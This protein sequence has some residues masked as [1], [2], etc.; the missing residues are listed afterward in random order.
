[1]LKKIKKQTI[2]DYLFF[3]IIC[4]VIFKL[5]FGLFFPIFVI[6]SESM[7]PYLDVGD[8]VFIKNKSIDEYNNGCIIVY[9]PYGN[10]KI[11]PVIHRI[12]YYIYK[13]ELMWPFGPI[14]QHSGFITKGDNNLL[15]K[16]LDQQS[17]ICTV[18]IKY[19]WVIG[20]KKIVIK[21]VGKFRLYF[22]Y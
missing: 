6:Q 18:P 20:S 3:I 11:T 8:V 12:S 19:N 22:P 2:V 9:Y 17:N 15:N 7:K 13:G 21:Y 10:Y 5:I 14:A 1:M 4:F 16:K